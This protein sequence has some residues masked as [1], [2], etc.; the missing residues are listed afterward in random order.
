MSVRSISSQ[1]RYL[2]RAIVDSINDTLNNLFGNAGREVLLHHLRCRHGVKPEDILNNPGL[3]E[4]CLRDI[5]GCCADI[6]L[7]RIIEESSIRIG[8]TLEGERRIG[9]VEYIKKIT[10]KR[11]R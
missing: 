6:I 3:F 4:N 9:F 7:Y 8:V 2:V 5:F 1:R 11:N 10:I